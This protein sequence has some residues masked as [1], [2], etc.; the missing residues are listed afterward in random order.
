VRHDVI[1]VPRHA[2]LIKRDD[3]Q[4]T[5]YTLKCNSSQCR[6]RGLEAPQRGLASCQYALCQT[7]SDELC[8]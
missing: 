8:S 2:E 5:R 3:L 1:R 6:S 7:L 4:Q